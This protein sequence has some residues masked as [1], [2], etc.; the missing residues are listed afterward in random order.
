MLQGEIAY[1]G[2]AGK[3]MLYLCECHCCLA[4][5]HSHRKDHLRFPLYRCCLGGDSRMNQ[6]E[7]AA[8]GM[9]AE[10]FETLVDAIDGRGG[11]NKMVR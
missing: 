6:Q 8:L 5:M 11:Q 10:D 2:I 1:T 9:D 7:A 3:V 4:L